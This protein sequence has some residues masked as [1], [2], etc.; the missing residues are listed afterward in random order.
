MAET[1]V[2]S[3]GKRTKWQ[4]KRKSIFIEYFT[5]RRRLNRS[6]KPTNLENKERSLLAIRHVTNASASSSLQKKKVVRNFVKADR[7]V[8]NNS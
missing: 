8:I 5:K 7:S 1:S 4:H 6:Q 2:L 3:C